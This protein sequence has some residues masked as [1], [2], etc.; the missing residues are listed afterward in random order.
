MRSTIICC[1]EDPG[2]CTT[3][4]PAWLMES[5]WSNPCDQVSQCYIYRLSEKLSF[6]RQTRASHG[7]EAGRDISPLVGS[8]SGETARHLAQTLGSS[9]S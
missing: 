9:Q 4:F 6:A 5:S 1:G 7:Q 3:S 2:R 8:N